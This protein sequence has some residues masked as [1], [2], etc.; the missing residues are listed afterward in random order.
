MPTKTKKATATMEAPTL[1]DVQDS[2]GPDEEAEA[3]EEFVAADKEAGED[4]GDAEE[5]A[6]ETLDRLAG[7]ELLS[8]YDDE[9]AKGR[10][11]ADI[12]YG[13]G[14]YT[15]TK[16][17]Q[18]RVMVAQFNA[19]M[20]EAQGIN[21]GDK[22]SGAGR[23]HAGLTRARVSGQGILLVSQLATR[24]VGAEP[25]GVFSVEYPTGDLQGPGAQILL[26]LTSDVK[27]VVA[28]KGKADQEE[29]GTPLLDQ[30]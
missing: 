29:P 18:E 9:K 25:G 4:P 7:S 1:D 11:H 24:S 27:P 13:A 19:A 30:G 21:V 17:G 2:Y 5:E 15:V 20:L 14:Y 16:S 12:A 28:R 22:P 26:T 3:S 23:S 6:G 10:S 8:F